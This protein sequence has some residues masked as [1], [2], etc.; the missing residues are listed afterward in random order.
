[1]CHYT[2]DKM[3]KANFSLFIECVQLDLTYTQSLDFLVLLIFA[4]TGKGNL[5]IFTSVFSPVS[6]TLPVKK[7]TIIPVCR[8]VSTTL[9]TRL[10]PVTNNNYWCLWHWF[11][12]SNCD[13][14]SDLLK[15]V[16]WQNTLIRDWGETYLWKTPRSKILWH[17]S[18]NKTDESD[19]DVLSG[20]FE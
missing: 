15:N 3:L 18:F 1:M 20:A 14:L 8:S 11:W 2:T 9:A 16:K 12:T 19:Q 17:C 13:N 10:L 7:E 5:L 6:M 4:P